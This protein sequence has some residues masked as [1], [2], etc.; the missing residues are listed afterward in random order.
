[1][2][3]P[4]AGEARPV[5]ARPTEGV[6]YTQHWFPFTMKSWGDR[7]GAPF[8]GNAVYQWQLYSVAESA[9]LPFYD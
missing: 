4:L 7:E 9:S 1:M 6:P 5:K 3:Y 2:L 8:G